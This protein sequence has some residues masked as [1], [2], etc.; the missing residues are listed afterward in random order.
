MY[1]EIVASFSKLG[2]KVTSDG[3]EVYEADKRAITLLVLTPEVFT[4]APLVDE[5]ARYVRTKRDRGSMVRREMSRS[6][7]RVRA[8]RHASHAA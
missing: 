5:V 6:R 4:C 1:D 7:L 3:D 2:V 8:E